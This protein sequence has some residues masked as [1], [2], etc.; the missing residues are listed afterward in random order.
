[1]KENK[2]GSFE[3]EHLDQPEVDFKSI[4]KFVVLCYINHKKADAKIGKVEKSGNERANR[5]L[6][7]PKEKLGITAAKNVSI[8]LGLS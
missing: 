8:C 2:R 3:T 7:E 4:V 6:R 1:M 5:R